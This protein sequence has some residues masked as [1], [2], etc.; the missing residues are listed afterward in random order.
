[1]RDSIREFGKLVTAA[2]MAAWIGA[3]H[4]PAAMADTYVFDPGHTN[5]T[6]SWN[7]LGLS[8]Q[9]G[10]VL[11][12]EGMLVFDPMQPE[13][14]KVDVTLKVASISTGAKQ[15]D[16][17]LR[18]SDFFDAARFP[19]ITFR[20]TLVSKTGERTGDV[21]GD[22]TIM[23]ETRPVVL[24]VRW[25]YTGEHPWSTL[26]PAYRGKFVSGFSAVATIL[27]SEWGLKR[28]TPLVSDEIEIA[29]ETEL[30]RR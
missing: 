26:N 1:M 17:D 29:I 28:G 5:I 6:F 3:A 11:E 23:G 30:T 14:A 25:N 24:Q 7:N 12:Y 18:S 10:R 21:A 4:V 2:V 22:L 19:E 15:L 16:R 13:D 8:R 20:S 9:S 27:R